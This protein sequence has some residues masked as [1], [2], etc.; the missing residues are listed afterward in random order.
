MIRYAVFGAGMMGRVMAQ[1]LLDT[2]PDARVT[3]LDSSE[4]SLE[5]AVELIASPRL[6]AQRTDATDRSTLTA[7]LRNHDV[8][9]GALPHGLSLPLVEAA[10][11]AGTPLVDLVGSGP[12]KRAALGDQARRAGCLVVP[13]CGVAPGISNF[14]VGRGVELLD[15]AM[16][17]FIYVGGI[18]RRKQPPLYYETVYLLESVFNA[19]LREAVILENGA[20]VRVA[21]LS[22]RETVTFPEPIGALEAFYTDGLASLALTM[23][24]KIRNRLFEKTLRY[25]GHA[26]RIEFLKQC[27]LLDEGPVR[28]GHAEVSPRRLTLALLQDTLKLG[29][30]G[31]VLVMRVIVEGARNGAS[32]KHTFELVDY[33]DPKTRYTA[34]ARTTGFT[35]TCTARMTARGEIPE[36][37]VLFPEQIFL[38]LR[39]EKML[40]ALAEKGVK[41]SHSESG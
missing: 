23:K 25:P 8:A 39:F 2:D 16:D 38:G 33:F 29:P 11:T 22:G 4:T 24:G 32:R 41:V 1:D 36:R 19:Y 34:M 6:T 17:A 9:L 27:G 15:E 31:D 20:E 13:G 40:A 3:L 14:C 10:V 37:G 12:E 21:P 28:V 26:E 35:A 30:E 18:P 7:A 5:T